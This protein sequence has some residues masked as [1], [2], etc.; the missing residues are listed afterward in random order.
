MTAQAEPVV[1]V[2]PIRLD[3]GCGP[4]KKEGFIGV[5]SRPFDGKVDV[6]FNLAAPKVYK[7]DGI[8][9]GWH[10]SP[11]QYEP[12]PWENDSVEEV[13]CSHFVEHL[14]QNERIHFVNELYRVMKVGAK[15]LLIT[16]YW[17]SNRAYGDLTHQWPPVSE[18][19]FYYLDKNWRA[20][21]AP[22]NDKYTCDFA[23]TWGYSMHQGI[24]ARNQE[25]QQHALTYWKEAAQDLIATIIKR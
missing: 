18:M 16:P 1:E 25:Y 10:G 23:S 15:A 11:L 14:N 12:W 13:H 21:N 9:T 7:G 6:V 19:W 4:N 24:M 3:L 22:H 2:K 8:P 5:D 20:Q 17:A